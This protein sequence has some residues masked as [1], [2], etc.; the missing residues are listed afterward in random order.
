MRTLRS[1]IAGLF[2]LGALLA[3]SRAGAT[4]YTLDP[5]RTVVTFEMRSLGTLQRGGFSRTAGTVVLESSQERGEV[6]IVIDARSLEASN[7]ATTK[8]MRGPSMLNTQAHPEIAYRAEHVVFLHGKPARIEGEL[9]LLGITRSVA[10]QI[11]SYDCDGESSQ[12]E[13]CAIV[14]TADV[15][16]SD[17]GMTHY[18]LLAAD[19]VRLAI[20]AE[21]V[22]R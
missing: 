10:L 16:R 22:T 6:D 11:S 9:T 7:A 18:M 13:R 19:D 4:E 2:A 1:W 21:G 17:F 3:H 8:F 15:N 20:Q 14:A 5:S 12:R